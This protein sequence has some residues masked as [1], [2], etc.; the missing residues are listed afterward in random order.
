MSVVLIA[1]IGEHPAIIT[2]TVDV[3]ETQGIKIEVVH[4]LCPNERLINEGA[5]WAELELEENDKVQA[6]VHGLPFSDSNSEFTAKQYFQAMASVLDPCRIANDEVHVLLAGGRKNISALTGVI[7]QFFPCVKKMYHILDIYEGDPLRRNLFSVEEL[8]DMSDSE[9]K[10]KMHPPLDT[11]NLFE[12]PFP[13]FNKASEILQYLYNPLGQEVPQLN[14]SDEAEDF[15]KGI[16]QRKVE[17]NF[18]VWLS[19]IAFKQFEDLWANNR[20]RAEEF[21]KC[22][23]QMKQPG[24]LKSQNG[25]H[26]TFGSDKATFH[27]YKR[28]M[29]PERPFYYTK[30]NPIHLYP[31]KQ[32]NQVIVSGLTVEI[33]NTYNVTG[34]DWLNKIND[35]EFYNPKHHLSDLPENPILLL[36]TLGETKM[37]ISQAYTLLQKRAKDIMVLIVYPGKHERISELAKELKEDF[38]KEKASCELK[39]IDDLVDVNSTDTCTFYLDAMAKIINE[40]QMNFSDREIHLLLSGGRKSMAALNLFAAQRVGLSTVW[41]TLVKEQQI[42]NRIERELEQASS[43]KVRRDILFLRKYPL[44]NFELFAVPVIPITS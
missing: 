21:R 4:I 7:A 9:R 17:P 1:P 2:A 6:E 37:V 36:A 24:R 43:P 18:D 38:E 5:E 15:Y 25:M 44:D 29:T 30:P 33:N 26:G 31:Q 42:E 23:N 20:N 3:L 13:H 10:R 11:V 35:P 41:H 14:L 34:E 12:V 32:V 22:F 8:A 27:F 28:R 39:S 16:F 19:N 40:C